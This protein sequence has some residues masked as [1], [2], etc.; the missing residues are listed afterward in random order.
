MKYFEVM[1]YTPYC[2]EHLYGYY[3]AESEAD[4]IESGRTDDLIADCIAEWFD[5]DEY[6]TYGF[7]SPEEYEEYYHS[8]SGCEIHEITK[9]EYVKGIGFCGTEV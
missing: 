1:A 8:D 7:D 6:E 5:A 2:G 9:E 4:L 3:A